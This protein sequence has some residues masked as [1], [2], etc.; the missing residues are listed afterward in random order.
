MFSLSH[1]RRSLGLLARR[2]LIFSF[3]FLRLSDFLNAKRFTAGE[4]RSRDSAQ[5]FYAIE[6]IEIENHDFLEGILVLSSKSWNLCY[7]N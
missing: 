1:K 4:C 3:A 7:R 5:G 6:E 2:I